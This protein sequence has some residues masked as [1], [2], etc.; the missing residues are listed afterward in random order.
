MAARFV[1]GIDLGTTNTV[2]A[3]AAVEAAEAEHPG[4]ALQAFPIPQMLSPGEVTPLAALPSA[5]YLP[6]PSELPADQLA[7]PWSQNTPSDAGPTVL[8]GEVAKRLGAKTPGRL[9]TSAKSWLCHAGVD[10]EAPILPWGAPDEVPRL[11]PLTA[12]ALVLQH[13]RDAWNHQHPDAL[14]QDQ[15]VVL[16]VPASFDEVARELTVRAAAQA[17]LQR[18]TLL[19]EPQAAFYDFVAAQDT[20][21]ATALKDKRLILVVDVGG[22]TT[23][24]TLMEAQVKVNGDV[25]LKRLAVGDHI[26][27]GGDNMDLALA[28]LCEHK[29]LGGNGKLDAA[30][31]SQLVHVCRLAKQALLSEKGGPAKYGVSVA[32]RGSKLIGGSIKV[33]L[34]RDEALRLLVDG[35][36]PVAA[37]DA[38]TTRTRGGGLMELGLPYASE[39]AIPRHISAFLWRHAA[40][41]R[42]ALGLPADSHALPRPDAVLLNGGVFRAVAI[43]EALAKVFQAWFPAQ[44]GIPLLPYTSLDAAV[45]RGAAYHGLTRRGL[46][47]RIGGGTARAFYV[48]LD[49]DRALCLVPRGHEGTD[50]LSV[51]RTF[52]LTVGKPA[53]FALY[54]S[55]TLSHALGEVV[56]LQPA[57]A[58]EPLPPIQTVLEGKGGE[59][60]VQ[61]HASVTDIGT[62]ELS[63]V[64]QQQRWK[65]EF[66][67]RGGGAVSNATTEKRVEGTIPQMQRGMQ[68]ARDW[69]D[70]IYGR[71]PQPV[72]PKDIKNLGRT[73]AKILGERETWN[74]ATLRELF[75]VFWAGADRRRR[76]TD[77]ERIWFQHIGY[78]LRPGFGA[79][80]DQFRVTDVW[81]AFE[82]GIT[83]V[84]QTQN[85]VE[86]WVMWR[87]VAGGLNRS[88]QQRI[89]QT[90]TPHL[91][92]H[93]GRT[94]PPKPKGPKPEG[95]DEM[96]RLLASLERIT[97]DEK[98]EAGRWLLT[99]LDAPDGA[100]RSWWPLG[101]IG[102]RVPFH[103]PVS[104]VVRVATVE[105]WLEKLLARDW[106]TTEGAAFAG[107]MM[108]RHTGDRARDVSDATRDKVVERLAQLPNSERWIQLVTH[109]EKELA[110][111]DQARVLGESLPPGLRL[112]EEDVAD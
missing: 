103:G 49:G 4:R 13:V 45:A 32:S 90:L 60:P 92:P 59:V 24:L 76:S 42:V 38:P 34:D 97:A 99:E 10:R 87:R 95:R 109:G 41:A 64:S 46:G 77:H 21:L 19:E 63:C 37:P 100:R 81:G 108:A 105:T 91:K 9:I 15:Q 31:W 94:P 29:A 48:G 71:R 93:T 18:L 70:R 68:E 50:D 72:E 65:L 104:D 14:L 79:P 47:H 12:S 17:G 96:V 80:L 30:Q 7:L 66:Q 2:V 57:D 35:F 67:L 111:E 54:A 107:T 25:A 89:F 27:L 23:D 22:G 33:E 101:R 112:M 86:W 53:R 106:K 61:L 82:P 26:L 8:L 55:T 88:Q 98:A 1:V 83:H 40:Q 5:L 51:P 102:A 69:V 84:A 20:A 110:V 78:C 36:F 56:P 75:G 85:W 11:S 3:S 6:H 73:L 28:R 52:A 58:F 62:L 74:T 44:Q 43:R 16:T 39:V